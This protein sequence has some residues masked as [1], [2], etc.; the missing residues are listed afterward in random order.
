MINFTVTQITILNFCRFVFWF[1]M[2]LGL[3]FHLFISF[4]S[5]SLR[6]FTQCEQLFSQ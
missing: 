2:R 5:T 3:H 1:E 6:L 4:N